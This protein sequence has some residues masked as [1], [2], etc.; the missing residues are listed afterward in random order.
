VT[1]IDATEIPNARGT[2]IL[3][4]NS[5]E[6][7]SLSIGRVGTLALRPGF[8]LYV[9]S[10]FG[11]GGLQARLLRHFRGG[12]KRHWHIDYLR[13]YADAVGAWLAPDS[14]RHEHHWADA[15]S[16]WSDLEPAMPGFGASDCRCATHLFFSADQPSIGAF[17]AQLEW[18][19]Y[20]ATGILNTTN[21]DQ[22]GCAATHER[23]PQARGNP[24]SRSESVDPH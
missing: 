10:A 14:V 7:R 1:L 24:H 19:G 2:Y 22:P 16:R 11:P 13:E 5:H 4:L 20:P 12:D 8:Y 6:T 23:S 18:C 15:L 9:G 17:Q 3:L 21:S